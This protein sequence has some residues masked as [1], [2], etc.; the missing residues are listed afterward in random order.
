MRRHVPRNPKRGDRRN[1]GLL[2]MLTSS[3]AGFSL[4]EVVVGAVLVAS[5]AGATASALLST[6]NLSGDQ[7][8]RAQAVEIAQ[9]DQER[10]RGMSIKALTGLDQTREVDEAGKP[11]VEP[12]SGTRFSVRSIGTFYSSSGASACNSTGTNAAA[13]VRIMTFVDWAS[14]RRTDVFQDALI[15]P[16]AG[17]SLL[18]NV[19]DQNGADLQGATVAATGPESAT[20]TT[21]EEGCTVFGAMTIGDY[22]VTVTKSGFVDPNG[23]VSGSIPAR[24]ATVGSSGTAFPTPNPFQIGEAGLASNWF[25]TTIAGTTY[26]GQRSPSVSWKDLTGGMTVSKNRSNAP[27]GGKILPTELVNTPDALFPFNNGT[28]GVYTNNYALWAGNCDLARPPAANQST[29]TVPPNGWAIM[30]DDPAQQP[31]IKVPALIL[32]F[33]FRS[34]AGVTSNVWPAAIKLRHQGCNQE[35]WPEPRTGTFNATTNNTFGALLYPGQPYAPDVA[36][37]RIEICADYTPNG[38]TN[39]YRT[40]SATPPVTRNNDFTTGTT[41]ATM[42]IDAQ[43]GAN[44]AGRC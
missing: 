37:Q 26:T 42:L 23:N 16:T 11:I 20:A 12:Y 22:Q 19:V 33:Q 30:N 13:Y 2:R 34:S 39:W 31:R 6:S 43:G 28:S 8:R 25:K 29:A 41:P 7:R 14:N 35:W 27:T 5:I 15:T 44:F 40:N 21:D 4:I 18:T 36:N 32:K 38:G 24:P 1:G 17:G 10:M 3:E 9:Q